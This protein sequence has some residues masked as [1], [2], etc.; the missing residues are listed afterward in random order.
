MTRKKLIFYWALYGFI[1]LLFLLLQSVLLNRLSLVHGVHPVLLPLLVGLTA[2]YTPRGGSAVFA[3]FFGFLCDM[4]FV[5]AIPC[6]YLLTFTLCAIAAG[7]LSHRF[8]TPGFF[9]SLLMGGLSLL[10]T[11]LL[12]M[13]FLTFRTDV[14]FLAGITT[15]FTELLLSLPFLLLLHPIYSRINRFLMR[16]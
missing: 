4:L 13:F 3:F 10:L 12:Q 14:P 6:F 7:L 8:I 5:G 9:C 1:A 11:G 2:I 15:L 16:V